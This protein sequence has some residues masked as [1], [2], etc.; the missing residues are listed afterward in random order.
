[1]IIANVDVVYPMVDEG[2]SII[3]DAVTEK[4]GKKPWFAKIHIFIMT[5]VCTGLIIPTHLGSL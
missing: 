4:M 5:L 3:S 2:H 1:M